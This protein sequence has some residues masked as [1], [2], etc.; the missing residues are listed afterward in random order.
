MGPPTSSIADLHT[1]P[2][3]LWEL[4]ILS[5]SASYPPVDRTTTTGIEGCSSLR[6]TPLLV[7]VVLVSVLLASPSCT[8]ALPPTC[9]TLWEPQLSNK[10]QP[11]RSATALP[12]PT[13]H[14]GA[15]FPHHP[16]FLYS[17]PLFNKALSPYLPRPLQAS[18]FFSRCPASFGPP[19]KKNGFGL[20]PCPFPLGPPLPTPFKCF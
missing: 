17:S 4:R 7:C 8:T 12:N 6:S 10:D 14:G 18:H 1:F 9:S 11:P 15:R 20:L 13:F 16:S 5:T 19:G 2:G 3:S